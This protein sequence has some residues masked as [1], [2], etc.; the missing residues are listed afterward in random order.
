MRLT[1]AWGAP[2]AGALKQSLRKRR[3]EEGEGMGE[4]WEGGGGVSGRHGTEEPRPLQPGRADGQ[5]RADGA[6]HLR[7][8]LQ[9]LRVYVNYSFY[10]NFPSFFWF[11]VRSPI[12]QRWALRLWCSRKK[13]MDIRVARALHPHQSL[14]GPSS[15]PL[16]TLTHTHTHP[17]PLSLPT[18]SGRCLGEGCLRHYFPNLLAHAHPRMRG[19]ARLLD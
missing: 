17:K 9:F 6:R 7:K 16:S 15:P 1:I 19:L 13:I 12:R 2:S 3:P 11:W 4:E 18:L 14:P 5:R 10:V 8:A